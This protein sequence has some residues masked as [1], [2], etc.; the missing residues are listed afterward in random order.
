MKGYPEFCK[1]FVDAV[2]NNADVI[3]DNLGDESIP[4]GYNLLHA[5][6]LMFIFTGTYCRDNRSILI[7]LT[8]EYSRHIDWKHVGG[9]E[10]HII[11]NELEQDDVGKFD[12]SS[13]YYSI[14]QYSQSWHLSV[15]PEFIAVDVDFTQFFVDDILKYGSVKSALERGESFHR[16]FRRYFNSDWEEVAPK[17]IKKFENPH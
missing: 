8:M 15:V 14:A 10:Y 17:V 12:F 9:I 2:R 7:E 5:P 1:S 13:Y 16:E 3:S 6:L 4:A 11:A